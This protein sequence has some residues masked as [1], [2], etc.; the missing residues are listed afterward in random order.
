[1]IEGI[2]EITLIVL[3]IILNGL[4]AATYSALVN[5]HPSQLS[6]LREAGQMGANLASEVAE[7]ASELILS[8]RIARGF[9]RL[10]ALGSVLLFFASFYVGAEGINF[11]TFMGI[12]LAA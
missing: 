6:Q 8:M 4:L 7:E 2:V 9:T 10:V 12:L 3:V 11:L 5:S 1:M